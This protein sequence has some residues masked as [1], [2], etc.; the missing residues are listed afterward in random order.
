MPSKLWKNWRSSLSRDDRWLAAPDRGLLR[1]ANPDDLW[2]W[3]HTS[4]LSKNVA[5]QLPELESSSGSSGIP[6]WSSDAITTRSGK[7]PRPKCI[8]WRSL[9]VALKLRRFPCLNKSASVS[10]V[11]SG[12]QSTRTVYQSLAFVM[13]LS[14]VNDI[15]RNE[16]HFDRGTLVAGDRNS[17]KQHKHKTRSQL[18]CSS[19]TCFSQA[20][21]RLEA[22]ARCL[23][24]MHAYQH[25]YTPTGRPRYVAKFQPHPQVLYIHF[26]Q[27]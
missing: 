11:F 26:S 27:W 1:F 19:K 4:L 20:L 14:K 10:T 23:L 22:P 15:K 13:D 7:G 21:S 18:C 25:K 2:P 12:S 8:P 16:E 5:P 3:P 6:L 24:R 17:Y 9:I